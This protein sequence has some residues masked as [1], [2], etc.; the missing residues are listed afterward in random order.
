MKE[1]LNQKRSGGM[2]REK[3]TGKKQKIGKVEQKMRGTLMGERKKE[4]KEY[5]KKN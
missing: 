4:R 1:K 3:R 2:N 5:R